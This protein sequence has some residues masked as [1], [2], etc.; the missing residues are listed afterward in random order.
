MN[1]KI[2]PIAPMIKSL[3]IVLKSLSRSFMT[4]SFEI[5]GKDSDKSDNRRFSSA[6]HPV[7]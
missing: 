7:S 6:E 5:C 4:Y 1:N 2:I 3:L